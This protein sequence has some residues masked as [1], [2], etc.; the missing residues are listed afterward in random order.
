[1]IFT[2]LNLKLSLPLRQKLNNYIM[3]TKIILLIAALFTTTISYGQNSCS[4]NETFEKLTHKIEREYPGFKE[5]TKDSILYHTFKSKLLEEAKTTEKDKCFDLLKKYTSFFRDSHIW[6][7]PA[8]S[9]NQKG[10]DSIKSLEINIDKFLKK[11]KNQKSS[12]KGVWKNRFEWTGGVIYDIGITQSGN[13]EYTGFV[14][15]SSSNFWKPKEIK[16]KLFANGKY[17]FYGFDKTIKKGNYEIF[18]HQIIHF[19]EA[20]SLFI[21]VDPK[22]TL[23][24]DQI[25][26]KVAEYYRFSLKK[27]SDKTAI[28]TMPS[29]DYP[30]VDI[31]DKLIADNRNLIEN[32]E[33]LIVDIRGNSG[34]T[35]NAYQNLLPYIMTN[36]I[37]NMGV[38]YLATPTLVNGLEGYIKTVED[39]KE[40]QDEAEMV[41]NWIRLF[42]KDMGKFVNVKDSSFSVQQVEFAKEGPKN[43][44]LLTD[45]RVGSSGEN[46]VMKTK[47]S[48]KV[49]VIGTVTS[50]G[51]DYAAAH[52]STSAVRNIYCN[53]QLSV[54]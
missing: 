9:I 27:L 17:E 6:I 32:S 29:F 42:K 2:I 1:M 13:N 24:E 48:K 47:Q 19:K 40:K 34:G 43:V 45:K 30:F 18:D 37:R 36:S 3:K 5:K 41:K 31:I 53:Y 49:K 12:I 22:P 26:D 4:C 14:I 35:D 28:I 10:V 25:K 51:L 21:K 20:R 33:N 16:F 7:N 52:S 15:T 11:A 54:R 50:G 46:F 38:E 8:T 23:T 44:V 39:K